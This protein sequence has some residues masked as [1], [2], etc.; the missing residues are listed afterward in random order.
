MFTQNYSV[1]VE[2]GSNL[3][4]RIVEIHALS[5]AKRQP[6]AKVARQVPPEPYPR[7]PNQ[8]IENGGKRVELLG[9][10]GGS[11]LQLPRGHVARPG[12]GIALSIVPVPVG[13]QQPSFA[14]QP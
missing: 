11:L 13:G 8:A 3:N 5:P 10:P 2:H 7:P 6:V 9:K 1:A 12:H 4:R 14:L